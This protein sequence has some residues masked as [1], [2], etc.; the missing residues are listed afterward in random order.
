MFGKRKRPGRTVLRLLLAIVIILVVIVATGSTYQ[1]IAARM[2]ASKYPPPGQLIDVGGYNMHISC[3]GTGSP[4]VIFNTGQGVMS[5][6]WLPLQEM[7]A[8]F[9]TACAFDRAGYGWSDLGPT[10]RTSEL[11]AAELKALLEGAGVEGPYVLVSHSIAGIHDRVFA[12]LNPDLVA[13]MVLVDTS[14]H[15]QTERMGMS[16][17]LSPLLQSLRRCTWLSLIGYNRLTGTFADRPIYDID[18]RDQAAAKLGQTHTCQAYYDEASAFHESFSQAGLSTDFGDIPLWVLTGT[19]KGQD[20]EPDE[21]QAL[22]EVWL[23]LQR[24]MLG[25]STNS[26]H[27]IVEDSAHYIHNDHPEIVLQAI[28]AVVGEVRGSTDRE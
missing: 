9:T 13:G 7:V 8:K 22:I 4:P 5:L 11:M 3:L 21:A 12:R 23:E 20:L 25:F 27:V 6:N 1:L 19:A 17:D 18:L 26:H 14:H 15:N 2:D 10:P 28:Q 16:S 24:E